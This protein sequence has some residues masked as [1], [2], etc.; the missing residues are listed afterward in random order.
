MT[1]TGLTKRIIVALGLDDKYSNACPTPA[2]AAPLPKDDGGDPASGMINYTCIVGMLLYLCG[3]SHPDISFA[4]HQCT[5]YTFAPK[6]SHEKALIRIGRY[7]K[8]TMDKGLTLQL[9]DDLTLDCYPDADFSGLWN[10]ESPNDPHSVRSRTGYLIPLCNC[11][12]IWVSKLQTPIAL[13]MMEAEYIVLSQACR[14][15]FPSIDLV[16]ELS[17][18]LNLTSTTTLPRLH[19]RVHEDNVGA[20]TLGKLEPRHMTPRS[21]HYALKYHWFHEHSIPCKIELLKIDTHHQLGDIFTKGLTGQ[22]FST[23]RKTIMGW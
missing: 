19:I 18:T 5:Q 1:Q 8:G 7:L 11:P 4:V 23:L 14:D 22:W 3:H 17:A 6:W 2:K 12:I 16:N 15:L 9:T 20:L 10:Y 21:K 13:S